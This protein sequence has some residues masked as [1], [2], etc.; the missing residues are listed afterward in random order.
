MKKILNKINAPLQ[1]FGR[2]L[3]LPIG[4]MAPIGMVLGIS[5]ALQQ[6]YMLETFEFLASPLVS[7]F[8]SALINI[9]NVVF[10]N[11]PLLFAMGVAYG[12]SRKEKGI[13]VFSATIGYLVLLATMREFL[14]ITDQL[15]APEEM[16]KNAQVI[17]LGIQT[18]RVDV[19]GGMIMGIVAAL[20][21]DRFYNIQLPVYLAF[22]GGKKF[23][24]MV[25]IV[26]AV[27]LGFTLP[28]VWIGV[29]AVLIQLGF[30]FEQRI[31]GT[32]I[33]PVVNRML[34]PVGLHHVFNSMIRY[35][36][37]GGTYLVCGVEQIGALNALTYSYFDPVCGGTVPPE[38]MK[39]Y[40]RFMAQTQMITT[41]FTLPAVAL[42]MYHTAYDKYKKEAAGLL[43][44]LCATAF[45]GNVTEPME[46]TFMFL[47]PIL[48]MTHAV[49]DGI[50][51]VLLYI[52]GTAVGYI[53]GTI[54]DFIVFGIGVP[55]SGWF[56]IVWVGLLIGA[57]EYSIFRMVIVKFDLPTPGRE[58]VTNLDIKNTDM[59]Q[60]G[61]DIIEALGGRENIVHV[62]NCIT[63]LR[64]DFVDKT[65]I[66]SSKID[67]TGANGVI[68]TT[69]THI[70]IVYGPQVEFIKNSVTDQL[71]K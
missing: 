62:E 59:D 29:T 64:I 16:A 21:T 37:M 25:T 28:F 4:V 66:S 47:S 44:A 56:N 34:I 55:G 7:G 1:R 61:R 57:A 46:F 17:Q 19:L 18:V 20:V 10:G 14:V 58:K 71:K 63:R 15:V 27:G 30:I 9:S 36:E 68:F 35:T 67:A 2:T 45:F 8:F 40:T 31:L 42:A 41:L 50:A 5:K 12:L 11:I 70:H 53:R 24:P 43:V 48:Y 22:F 51:A 23:P 65:K 39:E 52:S 49:L 33:F 3:L 32:F 6:N 69:S 26:V 54:F 60:L 38:E 13:A